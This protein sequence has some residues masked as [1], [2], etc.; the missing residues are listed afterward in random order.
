MS[1]DWGSTESSQSSNGSNG[2]HQPLATDASEA[3]A[4]LADS[5]PEW[6]LEPP[7]M[8]EPRRRST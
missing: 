2:Q 1:V 4:A 7:V 6:T 5:F 3:W 8:L